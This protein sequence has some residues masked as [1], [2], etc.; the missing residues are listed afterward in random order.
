MVTV[1]AKFLSGRYRTCWLSRHW[2]GDP[3]GSCSL[4]SCKLSGP[5]P[6]T[7]AHLLLYCEDLEPARKRIASLWAQHL[8]D[9]PVLIEIVQK[10]FINVDKTLALQFLLDCSVL[11]DV[12]LAK[13][14]FGE[15]ILNS[16]FYLTR[17]FCYS[18]HKARLRLLGRW[19][20]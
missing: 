19:T 3:S 18:L 8:Q 13:Q 7:L 12:I 10:N 9:K 6:G 20:Y 1:Q 11:S 17:S 14:E 16:L 4:P 2:S 5:H 15:V